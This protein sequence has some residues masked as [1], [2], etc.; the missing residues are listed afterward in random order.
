MCG[1][2]VTAWQVAHVTC[3]CDLLPGSQL[4][5]FVVWVCRPETAEEKSL[6]E[7]ITNLQVGESEPS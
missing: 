1:A 7:E 4:G 2:D 6:K 3:S 5:S